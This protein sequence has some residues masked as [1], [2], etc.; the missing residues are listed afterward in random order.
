[1]KKILL[2]YLINSLPSE[3]ILNQLEKSFPIELHKVAIMA[4]IIPIFTIKN[5]LGKKQNQ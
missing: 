1:M 5:E 2:F 4:L 3:H